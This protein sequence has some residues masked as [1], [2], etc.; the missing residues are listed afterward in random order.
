MRLKFLSREWCEVADGIED[1]VGRMWFMSLKHNSL[2]GQL[3]M[4]VL[5][6]AL[7]TLPPASIPTAIR[8]H[9]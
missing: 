3:L 9:L 4:A 2:G 1:D 5:K 8:F 6:S 7:F